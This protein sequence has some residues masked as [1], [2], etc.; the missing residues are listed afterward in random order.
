MG[1]ENSVLRPN[2]YVRL[3]KKSRTRQ[4]PFRKN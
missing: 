3:S 2:A 4:N 1:D